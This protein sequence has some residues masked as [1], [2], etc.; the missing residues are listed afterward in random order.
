MERTADGENEF[1]CTIFYY[2]LKHPPIQFTKY[3]FRRCEVLDFFHSILP[4]R[5]NLFCR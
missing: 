5:I 3:M 2:Y 1:L 4:S